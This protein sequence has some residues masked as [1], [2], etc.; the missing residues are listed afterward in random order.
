MN[1]HV[2]PLTFST[3]GECV[4]LESIKG[5][6]KMSHHLTALGLT[7]GV[8][9]SIIQNSGGPMLIS[10]RDSRIALGLGMAQKLLVSLISENSGEQK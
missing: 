3:T 7:P 1:N 10:V 6:N 5:G 8:N 2:F 9:L 4:R